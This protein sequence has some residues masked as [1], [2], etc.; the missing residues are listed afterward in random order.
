MDTAKVE[1]VA[2]ASWSTEQ[3]TGA[4]AA[5]AAGG[6]AGAG[7]SMHKMLSQN[8][9]S[10]NTDQRLIYVADM[11]QSTH[12]MSLATAARLEVVP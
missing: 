1:A 10:V 5:A 9:N 12:H 3:M 7:K 11:L 4:T 2:T 8:M 6:G